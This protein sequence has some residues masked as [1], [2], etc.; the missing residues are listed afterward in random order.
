MSLS[1]TLYPLLSTGSTKED[2]RLSLVDGCLKVDLTKCDKLDE[3]VMI[4]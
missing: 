2:R 1:K 4:L 3:M